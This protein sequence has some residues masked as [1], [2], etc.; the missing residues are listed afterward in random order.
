[1]AKTFSIK[2]VGNSNIFYI[3]AKIGETNLGIKFSLYSIV[4]I[5][6]YLYSYRK[7]LGVH[8]QYGR[9]A[10]SQQY[11]SNNCSFSRNMAKTNKIKCV[12]NI[13]N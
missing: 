11:S 1:M 9:G 13:S 4:P 2:C 3:S 7:D 12:W 10:L 6:L 8:V 5:K